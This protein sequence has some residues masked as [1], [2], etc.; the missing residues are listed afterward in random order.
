MGHEIQMVQDRAFT[1]CPSLARKR[2]AS[3]IELTVVITLFLLLVGMVFIG[4]KTWKIE[5]YE[6]ACFGN[7]HQLEE[8][9]VLGPP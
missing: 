4:F 7:V 9:G 6:C 5:A 2:G 3:I 8:V 1:K